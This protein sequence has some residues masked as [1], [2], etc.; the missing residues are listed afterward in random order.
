[1][2]VRSYKAGGGNRKESLGKEVEVVWA[3]DE[4]RGTLRRKE[5]DENE[6]K[7]YLRRRLD[8][9]KDDTKVKRRVCRQRKCGAVGRGSVRPCYV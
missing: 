9:M 7:T 3:C 6:M 8:K 5:V 2:D 4:K 1:M